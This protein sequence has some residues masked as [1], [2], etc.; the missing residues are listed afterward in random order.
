LL[1][2]EELGVEW[3]EVEAHQRVVAAAFV[4]VV[5]FEVAVFVVDSLLP[6]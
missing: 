6:S 5:F 1:L 2:S 4:A 3:S